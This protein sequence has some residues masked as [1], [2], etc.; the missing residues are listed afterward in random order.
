MENLSP[1]NVD[2]YI[3]TF[4]P[5]TQRALQEVRAAIKETAPE[6]EELISYAMPAYKLHKHQL[7]YFAAFKNHIGFY[8][9]PSGNEEFKKELSQYKTGKGSIQFP[10]NQPMPSGLIKKIVKFR[11]QENLEKLSAKKK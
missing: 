9:L 11:M 1:I 7:V 10:L 5:G 3:A 8:A 4:P 6:A 2:A